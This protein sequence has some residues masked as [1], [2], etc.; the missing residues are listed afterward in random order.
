MILFHQASEVL[1]LQGAYAKQGRRVLAK[2]LGLLKSQSF[3]VH[4][5]QIV[6]MGDSRKVPR[7][8]AKVIKKEISLKGLLVLPGLIECHTHTVFAGSRAAEFELRQAGASYQEIS[9]KGGG[10][11][12]T[13]KRT[14]QMNSAELL[15]LTQARVDRFVEQG[16]SVLEIKSGY[17][18]D[19]KSELKSLEVAKKIK[20]PRVVTTFLGAHARPPEFTSYEKYLDYLIEKV[21]P[22]VK[23]KGLA[24]RVD[25]FI[26]KGFFE[27]EISEK[28]LSDAQKLGFSLTIHADQL[29]LSGGSDVALKLKALSADHVIQVDDSTIVR[30]AKSDVTCVAL[31]AADLYLKCAYPPARKMIDAG[32]RVA[33]ATDFNPGTAPTQD[34]ALVGILARLEMKMS[35]PEVIAAYTVNAAYALGLEKSF[36]HL[37]LRT[38]AD[39]A[40]YECELSD[41]FYSVGS[42]QSA[43]TISRGK[44]IK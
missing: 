39:F 23:K 16:V 30:L 3:V 42:M 17:G 15:K 13:V 5:Q 19:L 33:L 2:D 21:L 20:G 22:E 32:A 10:I 7:Q 9:Q 40:C 31:P 36:G 35:L 28:Y 27:K 14:R 43:M 12:S 24:E 41:L 6:W 25:I 4:Q 8:Y 11:I 26:E 34:L 29:T 38:S 37:D 1:T 18:L 44:V